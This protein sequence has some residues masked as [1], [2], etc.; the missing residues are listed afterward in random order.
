MASSSLAVVKLASA[1]PTPEAP[2]NF[3]AREID[4]HFSDND[5]VSVG[6]LS[7]LLTLYASRRAFVTEGVIFFGKCVWCN[8]WFSIG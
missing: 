1:E 7:V 3:P 5:I 4:G 6:N 8:S 2:G